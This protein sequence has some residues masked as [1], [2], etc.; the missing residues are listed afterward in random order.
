MSAAELRAAF[1]EYINGEGGLFW[2]RAVMEHYKLGT[3]EDL[4]PD[5][6]RDVLDHPER[7]R[8]VA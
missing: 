8:S 6:T 7:F 4:T 5:Q 1:T 3:L 2:A